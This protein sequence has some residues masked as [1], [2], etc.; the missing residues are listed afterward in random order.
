MTSTITDRV[1]VAVTGGS[2]SS[3][4]YGIVQCSS[5]AG[6]NTVTASCTPSISGYV[7]GQYYSIRPVATN[8][9]PM[10]LNLDGRG[11]TD[12]L[13]PAGDALSSGQ[14]STAFEYLV[15]FNGTTFRI[16]SPF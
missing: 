14:F 10:T 12:L 9:G 8:T 15:K 7:S 5:V 13:S 3:G 6:T 16:V 11:Q 2:V 1:A 4:G